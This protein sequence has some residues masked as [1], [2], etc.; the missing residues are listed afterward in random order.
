MLSAFLLSVLMLGIEIPNV[1][2]LCPC[3]EF[4]YADCKMLNIVIPGIVMLRVVILSDVMLYPFAE[5][6]YAKCYNTESCYAE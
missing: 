1:D 4:R 6:P 5:C 3:A 2:M